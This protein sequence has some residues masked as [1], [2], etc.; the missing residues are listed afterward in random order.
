LNEGEFHDRILALAAKVGFKTS[1]IFSMDGSKRSGH[2]NAYF[3]GF[4]KAKRIVFFDTLLQ[5]MS[6]EQA[7]AVLA[8]EMGHYKLKHIPRMLVVQL[9]FLMLGLFV[10]SLVL[11]YPPFYAAFGL[12]PSSHAALVLLTLISGPATFYLSPFMNRLSRR[13][14]YEADH[15]AAQTLGE[16]R[17]MEEALIKLTIK[18]LS[19]LAPH[20]WYS[21]YHYSHP[22]T[23]ERIHALRAS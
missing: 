1:G 13:H 8:H 19:N 22:T 10:L 7:L 17:S 12:T 2:S 21:A 14:E 9:A 3:T 11:S 18:N 15:F 23:G 4:G 20:P 16:N 6:I 5:Q